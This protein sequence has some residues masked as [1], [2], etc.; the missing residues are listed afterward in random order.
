M[1]QVSQHLGLTVDAV[2]DLLLHVILASGE[3]L[4][5]GPSIEIEVSQLF[6]CLALEFGQNL[7]DIDQI[8]LVG[9]LA[10]RKAD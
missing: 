6:Y 4:R 2:E 7:D 10:E 8:I 1:A 3:T 5:V 9:Q